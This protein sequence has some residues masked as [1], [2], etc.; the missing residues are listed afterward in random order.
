MDEGRPC[1]VLCRIAAALAE[2]FSQTQ[3]GP[4]RPIDVAK[5]AGVPRQV[6]GEVFKAL[7]EKGYVERVKTA[8]GWRAPCCRARRC[9]RPAAEGYTAY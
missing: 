8:G 1:G 6:V 5:R 2:V 4:L 7:A 9:G 3:E